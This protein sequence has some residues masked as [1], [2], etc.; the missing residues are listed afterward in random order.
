M[1][2]PGHAAGRWHYP[3]KGEQ[4]TQ[5]VRVLVEFEHEPRPI[6]MTHDYDPAVGWPTTEIKGDMDRNFQRLFDL[7]AKG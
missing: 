4:P 7:I 5:A 1:A 3:D 6:L 2:S